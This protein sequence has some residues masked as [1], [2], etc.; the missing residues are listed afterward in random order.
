MEPLTR[1]DRPITNAA[2]PEYLYYGQFQRTEELDKRIFE[3]TVMSDIQLRPN[4][5]PRPTTTRQTVF[6]IVASEKRPPI[7]PINTYLEYNTQNVFSP[8]QRKGPVAG[9]IDNVN[10]ESSLRNQ[11]FANQHGSIQSTYI[12][13]SKSDLYVV[14]VPT[15]SEYKGEQPFRGLFETY[16]YHTT[17]NADIANSAVGKNVFNNATKQ[18]LRNM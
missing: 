7:V 11:F 14:T 4:F 15:E 16:E 18:Q 5:E 1:A 12:P 17:G 6:P 8:Y 9:F 13:S 3:R 2:F 10:V